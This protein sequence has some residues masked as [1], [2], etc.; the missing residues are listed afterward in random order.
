M[1]HCSFVVSNAGDRKADM[2]YHFKLRDPNVCDDFEK[3]D[4]F[5]FFKDDDGT[6]SIQLPDNKNGKEA[7]MA[8]VI[9]RSA[10][11]DA[12]PPMDDNGLFSSHLKVVRCCFAC[13]L[14]DQ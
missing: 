10:N 14:K 3:G 6:S 5:G 11:L 4:V 8:G 2:G 12:R 9:T 1:E 13:W 7:F